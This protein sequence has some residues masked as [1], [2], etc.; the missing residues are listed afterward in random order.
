MN[1]PGF[2]AESALTERKVRYAS[3]AFDDLMEG[4]VRPQLRNIGGGLSNEGDCVGRYMKCVIGCYDKDT[5]YLEGC[6]DSCRASLN[7]C[8]SFL[9]PNWKAQVGAI[10]RAPITLVGQ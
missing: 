3:L 4:T 9:R 8:Q 6:L 5:D 2:T 1:L 7:L 10:G